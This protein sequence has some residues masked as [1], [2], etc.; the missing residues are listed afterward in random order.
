MT[1]KHAS[2]IKGAS[3]AK[4]TIQF[5]C[6]SFNRLTRPYNQMQ[7]LRKSRDSF[8]SYTRYSSPR[9]SQS[10]TRDALRLHTTRQGPVRTPSGARASSRSTQGPLTQ[11]SVRAVLGLLL[12]NSPQGTILYTRQARHG[13]PL[14]CSQGI[15]LRTCPRA[16]QNLEPVAWAN[17]RNTF[18]TWP[19]E[20]LQYAAT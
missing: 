10:S 20:L 1:C 13:M 2:H 12:N 11:V 7:A 17:F 9:F 4:L 18:R 8:S 5:H 14:H 6:T 3:F 15:L 19:R 16:V